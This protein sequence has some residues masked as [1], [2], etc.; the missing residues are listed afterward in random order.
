MSIVDLLIVLALSQYIFFTVR[1]GKARGTYGISA[2]ATTGN[3][4]FERFY[5]VQ[6]NTLEMLI[7]LIPSTWIASSYWNPIFVA[8]MIVIYLVGRQIYYASYIKEPKKRSLGFFLTVLPIFILL[9][10]AATGALMSLLQT[11]F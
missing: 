10:S 3:P 8:A 7:M 2:P 1:V 11:T 5:R 4:V 9:I 6:T